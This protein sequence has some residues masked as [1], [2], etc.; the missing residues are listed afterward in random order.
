MGLSKSLLRK[1]KRSGSHK[2]NEA[3]V[4]YR[5]RWN[6]RHPE[7]RKVYSLRRRISAFKRTIAIMERKVERIKKRKNILRED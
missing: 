3:K 1:G 6:R 5:E 2:A 4:K 7:G